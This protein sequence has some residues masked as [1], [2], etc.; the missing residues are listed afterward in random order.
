MSRRFRGLVVALTSL[1]VVLCAAPWSQAWAQ[2]GDSRQTSGQAP[3][4]RAR[5]LDQLVREFRGVSIPVPLV[6]P[7]PPDL[8]VGR[9][10]TFWVGQQGSSG[11][12]QVQA[13][14]RRVSRHAYWYVQQ[15][16]TMS[17]S[18]LQRASDSFENVIYPGVRRLVGAEPFPGID[19]D[20]RITILNGNV[21]GVAGYVSSLDSYSSAVSPY[22]N[23]REMVYLNTRSLEPGTSTYLG[24]LAHEF[25]HVVHGWVSATETTWIKEGTADSV[26]ARVL[27]DRGVTYSAFLARPDLQLTSWAEGPAG[28]AYYESA[29]LFMRYF[30]D[31][32][33]E[34]ALRP[35]LSRPGFG[36]ASID[37]FLSM[38]GEPSRFEDLF[39][40]WLAANVAGSRVSADF[41]TYPSPLTG[42]PLTQK[43]QRGGHIADTVSQFGADY[44]ELGAGVGGVR[45]FGAPTVTALPTRPHL[46]ERVWF[47]GREDSSVADMIR[48]VDLRGSESAE[49]RFW[50]WYDLEP[51]Y[52]F[53]YVSISSD[54]GAH[55]TLLVAP[56][57]SESNS[58]GN[59]LGMGYTGK[60]GGGPVASWVPVTLDL[61]P[62]GGQVVLIRFSYVTDDAVTRDGVALDDIEVTSVFPPD[63]AE[64]DGAEA[65]GAEADGAE[66][67]SG[68]WMLTGWSQLAGILPQRW[69][70][71]VLLFK[72]NQVTRE[73]IPVDGRGSATWSGAGKSFDRAIVVVAGVTAN[74]LQPASYV[75]DVV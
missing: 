32:F 15:G 73:V 9:V 19:N 27:P 67:E 61:R 41:F 26:A 72:G 69:S 62:Y 21:P 16:T 59:S 22:S 29:G 36:V 44:Y 5:E 23:Q 6:Q 4:P 56:D 63:G 66:D 18:A 11:H 65:D 30:M 47:G 40:D 10:D 68:E 52:D 12:F 51:D 35:F 24:V 75:L 25:T 58:S 64:A 70:L 1:G 74:T 55:W 14:I 48:R 60:S 39:G 54:E 17:E 71:Q 38:V 7:S 3:G 49:L 42:A 2:L 45:F 53:A 34:G 50:A 13:E 37:A 28:A 33:G 43:L 57:M 46:G 20:P 31:R 8:R